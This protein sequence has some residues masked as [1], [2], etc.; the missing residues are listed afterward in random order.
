[1]RPL[2]LNLA[3]LLTAIA[4][5]TS[6]PSTQPA[7]LAAELD[8]LVDADPVARLAARDEL[9]LLTRDDLPTLR[10]VVSERPVGPVLRNA[11]HEI[12]VHVYLTGEHNFKGPGPGRLGF[13]VTG[14]EIGPP[15]VGRRMP[16][17]DAYRVLEDGDTIVGIATDEG[18]KPNTIVPVSTLLALLN[19][20]TPTTP[21]EWVRVR[22]VRNG[23][24]LEVPIRL[25]QQVKLQP[26]GEPEPLLDIGER[27]WSESF[28]PALHAADHVRSPPPLAGEG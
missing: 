14:G 11:L 22:I 12:V 18:D 24:T 3:T 19:E 25:S 26:M 2:L 1:M 8:R 28:E 9:M 27:Y 16:G 23:Q 6:K 15:V 13:I 20:L 10:R 4:G 7:S 5:A 17:F 21:G